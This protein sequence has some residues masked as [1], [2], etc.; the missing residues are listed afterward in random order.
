MPVFPMLTRNGAAET[1]AYPHAASLTQGRPRVGVMFVKKFRNLNADPKFKV[2][3]TGVKKLVSSS[4]VSLAAPILAHLL[5]ICI[6]VTAPGVTVFEIKKGL[7][8]HDNPSLREAL[9]GASSFRCVYI[10]DPWFTD[11]SQVGIN[12]WRF[13]LQCLED[14]DSSLRKLNSRLYVVRGQ[15]VDV[16][17]KLFKEWNINVLSFEEDPEPF[18][19]SR[20]SAISALAQDIG[21]KMIV[22]ISHTLYDLKKIISENDGTPPLTFKRFQSVLSRLD[23]PAKPED[24]ITL[25]TICQCKT[26]ILLAHDDKYGIPSL[27]D[28]GFD[29]SGLSSNVF[30]G[31]ESEALQRLQGHLERKYTAPRLN[32]SFERRVSR[33]GAAGD[34]T[35]DLWIVKPVCYH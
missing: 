29:T 16:F 22:R 4:R 33:L 28:L 12:R 27:D 25:D 10:L 31:G 8:L 35:S 5:R 9:D 30:R 3:V 19:R 23:P 21:V 6:Q 14:L 18:G 11:V 15:P 20:D 2:K 26:P 13:L 17:P 24:R 1:D 32:V 34:R 7:R